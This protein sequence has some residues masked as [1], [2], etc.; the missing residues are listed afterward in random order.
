MKIQLLKEK[1]Y[2]YSRI[3]QYYGLKPTFAYYLSQQSETKHFSLRKK[4]ILEFVYNLRKKAGINNLSY[5]ADVVEGKEDFPK[6]IWTMWQQGEDQMPETVKASIKTIKTFAER[7]NCEFNLLTDENLHNFVEIPKDIIKKYK[8]KELK[9]AHFSDIVRFYLLYEYG[10]VWMDATLFVSPYATL[11]LFEGDFFSLNHPPLQTDQMKRTVG[12]YKWSGFLL[13]GKKGKSYFKNIRDLY[14]YYV[15]KYPIFIDY[16]IMDYFILSEY[17]SNSY[18]R[19]LVDN[20]RV[21]AHAESIWFFKFNDSKLFDENE[22]DNVLRTTP[23]MKTTYKINK[24]ELV[25]Q[26]YLY[27]LY[28]GELNE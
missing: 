27:K 23:I 18:Y 10:G 5:K 15:R 7:N 19:K 20:L 12:D 6:I 16:L 4:I 11:E 8:N 22:W 26:S 28:N 1:I 24:T 17:N 2:R 3:L 21:Y 9:P 13:A 25:P 14:V